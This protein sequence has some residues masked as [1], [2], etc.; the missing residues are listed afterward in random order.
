M[1]PSFMSNILEAKNISAYRGF[2]L[3]IRDLS[4]Q[5][6]QGC[7]TAILGPNG[8]GKS[9]LLML[10]TR[11]IY[12][13]HQNSG[14][15]KIFGKQ[16]WNVWELRTRLGMVSQDLQNQYLRHAQG[17]NVVLS[18]F[19]SSINIWSHQEFQPRDREMAARTMQMLGISYLKD[20]KFSDL[21]TGEQRL[22]LLARALVNNPGALVLDE[23]TSGLDLKSCFQYLQIVR[24]LIRQQQTVILVTHHIHEIPPEVE[25]VVFFKDGRIRAD[26][27]K[28]ELMTRERLE[29]LYETSLQLVCHNGFYQALPAT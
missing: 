7:N 23:P 29:D 2:T 20:R 13:L 18:G 26:G 22:L 24:N 25:R 19:Y 28:Q 6:P 21:S 15:L 16:D 10:L 3:A 14:Y 11:E 17:E 8:A 1:Y 9:T 4:L 27:D 12:P 5:I